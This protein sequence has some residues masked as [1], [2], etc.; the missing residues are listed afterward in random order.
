MAYA[1]WSVVFGEQPSAAKWNILGA[2]DASFNNGSGIQ[3]T[4]AI[5][6]ASGGLDLRGASANGVL[7][8]LRT[9]TD[10][11]N[12][13]ASA[14]TNALKIQSGW[15]A[16]IGVAANSVTETVT[17]PTAFSVAP[18]VSMQYI[19]FKTGSSYPTTITDT[20][21][22]AN[23]LCGAGNITTTNFAAMVADKVT[24][25][26]LSTTI[27]YAYTWIAIGVA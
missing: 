2:N 19:G 20:T 9:Q 18:I 6:A 22:G 5:V 7:L 1:A 15:G 8:Q 3:P 12:S 27:V 24:A 25:T 10:N 13:I 26:N 21:A 16:V 4:N 11:A 14:T 17:F 23:Q